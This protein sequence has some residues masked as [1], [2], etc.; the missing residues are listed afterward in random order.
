MQILERLTIENVFSIALQTCENVSL[1]SNESSKSNDLIL[2]N[3]NSANVKFNNIDSN[4]FMK[5]MI[6]MIEMVNSKRR[7]D[8]KMHQEFRTYLSHSMD[9]FIKK[10]GD[11]ISFEKYSKM[12]ARMI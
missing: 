4:V 7:T 1:Q 2:N 9:E 5:K 6:D 12:M 11:E 3:E 10:L 8:E